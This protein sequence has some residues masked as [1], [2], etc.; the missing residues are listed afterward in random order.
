MDITTLIGIVVAFGLVIISILMGGD[1]GWFVNY[2]SLMIVF[3]GTMGA[4]F[5]AYPLSEVLGVIKV[6]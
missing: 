1:G 5:L 2:P 6:A 4:T 3:G